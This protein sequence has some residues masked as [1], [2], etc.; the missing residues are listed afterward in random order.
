MILLEIKRMQHRNKDTQRETTHTHNKEQSNQNNMYKETNKQLRLHWTLH[1]KNKYWYRLETATSESILD[2]TIYNGEVDNVFYEYDFFNK[3]MC[4]ILW[5]V[6]IILYEVEVC[7]KWNSI[8][9]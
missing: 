4:L 3:K 2:C 7:T 6:I 8:Y 9:M 5:F 1:N